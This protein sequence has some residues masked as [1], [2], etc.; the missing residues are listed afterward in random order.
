MMATTPRDKIL[1]RWGALKTERSSWLTHWREISDYLLPRS[2][3]FLATDRNR[4]DK[5][6]N[7]IYDSTGTRALRVLAAG[8][9][10]GMTS[11]ARPWFRL[12]TADPEMMAHEPV[13]VWLHDVQRLMLDVFQRSNT[14]RA[15]HSMYEELGAFGTSASI[16]MDD[17]N[18]VLRHYSLTAGEFAIA[19]DYR[20]Q[21]TTLYREF[22]MTVAQMVG[23]FGRDKVSHAVRNLFDQGNLDAWVPVVHAIEPRADRDPKKRDAQNM[24]WAS[25]YFEQGGES[26]KRL[27]ESGFESFPALVPRWSASGGDIYGNSPGMEALGD[28]RQLQHEQLRKAQGIDYMTK[29]PLQAP[30]AMKNRDVDTLPGGVSFVDTASPTGGIRTAFEV[31]LD[32]NHLLM[33]IQDVRERVRSTFYADLFLMLA[34][35]DRGNMT[36]TEVAERHEEKLLMLGPVLERLHNELLDPFIEMTFQRMVRAGILPPAPPE[37]QGMDLNVEFVSML[38]QAQRAVGTNSVD[39]Y[40]GNL[41]MIAQMKPEVL[42]RFDA[43]EWAEIYADMLGVDPRLVVADDK[44]ALIRQQRAEAQAQAAQA[45]QMAQQAQTARNL[46][47]ADTSGQNALTDVVQMFSGYSGG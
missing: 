26:G 20:G 23:E 47:A 10:A 7:N 27:S 14:Y 21:I 16:V 31:R 29:P 6:H 34:G 38:A 44:V 30:T 39:R 40:V 19:A 41:G 17:Y 9:M 1:T 25:I 18:D 22:D 24:A 3:R 13:K 8:M 46:A 43:D 32:L 11:P 28:I 12:A 37:L 15:L 35:S 45:E 33:D 42:D 2:G 5:R 36:A 4:G